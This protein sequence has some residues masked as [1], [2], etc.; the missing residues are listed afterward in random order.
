[1]KFSHKEFSLFEVK[2][3]L[4][5]N[6]DWVLIPNFQRGYVWKKNKEIIYLIDSVL[7]EIFINNFIIYQDRIEAN[8]EESIMWLYYSHLTLEPVLDSSFTENRK[9]YINWNKELNIFGV[10]DWQQRLT[11]LYNLL[12]YWM[13]FNWKKLVPF[14]INLSTL[15]TLIKYKKIDWLHK[16]KGDEFDCPYYIDEWKNKD[17]GKVLISDMKDD[18]IL[19]TISYEKEKMNFISI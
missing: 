15:A 10:L 2:T 18:W 9:S 13:V 5:G 17:E 8:K 4:D 7:N 14:Y 19:S 1:M 12:Q 6:P 11:T 3:K 16:F